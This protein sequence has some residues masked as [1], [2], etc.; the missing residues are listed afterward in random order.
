VF[1]VRHLKKGK[2][3][4]VVRIKSLL[5]NIK[6]PLKNKGARERVMFSPSLFNAPLLGKS[7]LVWW[8]L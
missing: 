6:V 3:E 1:I 7:N 5:R 2:K 4:E 8:S